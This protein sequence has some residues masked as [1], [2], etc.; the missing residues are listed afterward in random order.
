MLGPLF[1]RRR[2]VALALVVLVLVLVLALVLVLVVLVLVL[3]VLVRTKVI[4]Q[5]VHV[6]EHAVLHTWRLANSN[7]VRQYA[8]CA[9]LI[10]G[11]LRT[12]SNSS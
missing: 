9:H 3:V 2:L 6:N 11:G 4:L 7:D 12:L 1:I 8:V 10:T 5:Q